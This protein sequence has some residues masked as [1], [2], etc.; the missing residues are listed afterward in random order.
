MSDSQNKTPAT[1]VIK[2]KRDVFKRKALRDNCEQVSKKSKTLIGNS[3]SDKNESKK[4]IVD[5]QNL[6]IKK[7][8]ILQKPTG[9]KNIVDHKNSVRIK[10]E[11]YNQN[12]KKAL[13]N[14]ILINMITDPWKTNLLKELPELIHMVSCPLTEA[15]E[16][17]FD[18]MF[19][20]FPHSDPQYW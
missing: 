20:E 13:Q 3:E 5:H 15:E 2:I 14:Y 12:L 17:E 19:P 4:N 6:A 18:E 7:N 9:V 10:N 8:E 16:K 1:K 11:T